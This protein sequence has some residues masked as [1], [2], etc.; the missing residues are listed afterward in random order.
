MLTAAKRPTAPDASGG[1]RREPADKP[2]SRRRDR[3]HIAADSNKSHLHGEG[4]EAPETLAKGAAHGKR[5][6]A[7]QHRRKRDNDNCDRNE[8]ERIGKPALRP[9][10]EG[11][12]DPNQRS[13]L[14]LW[15]AGN[16]VR[17]GRASL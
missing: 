11:D 12:G 3:D 9:R 8:N 1:S 13:V 10:G 6:G 17:F 2:L 16:S 15:A 5:R 14:L 4:N 7:V